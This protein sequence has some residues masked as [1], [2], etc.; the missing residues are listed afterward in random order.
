MSPER[1]MNRI[2]MPG[3]LR[4][5]ALGGPS[6]SD[7]ALQMVMTIALQES[8][9]E[10]RVQQLR[11][12]RAGPARGWYQFE[13]G[14]GVAGVMQHPASGHLA[15]VLCEDIAVPFNRNDIWR[16][17]EG[18]DDLATGF[19]RLLLWTDPRPL[20]V[21][22]EAGWRYY[23]DNWRPGKPHPAKWPTYWRTVAD[24][25]NSEK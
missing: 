12:G 19:A 7:A 8:A 23:L 14:G 1:F 17:L 2:A 6:V 16:C 13:L 25:I 15:R 5:N 22:P 10:H 21:T 11:S 9:M 20:P 3:L 24:T 4:L 18:N